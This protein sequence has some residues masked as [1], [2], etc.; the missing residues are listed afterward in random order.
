MSCILTVCFVGG[1]KEWET[2]YDG[3]LNKDKEKGSMRK[4]A[5]KVSRFGFDNYERTQQR[6]AAALILD[7]NEL[8]MMHALAR[9]DVCSSHPYP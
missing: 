4:R 5:D 6:R 7:N 2:I 1:E 8:I 9:G 3:S